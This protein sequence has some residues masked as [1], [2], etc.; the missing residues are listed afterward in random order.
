M[1]HLKKYIICILID[2]VI[3]IFIKDASKYTSFRDRYYKSNNLNIPNNYNN[4]DN[5]N[6]NINLKLH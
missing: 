5:H 2:I 6:N 4:P 3:G 1:H